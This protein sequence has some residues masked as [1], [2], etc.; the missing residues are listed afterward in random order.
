MHEEQGEAFLLHVTSGRY[1]GLN[2]SGVVVWNAL[3]DG[4]DPVQRLRDEWPSRPPDALENDA[5]VL[6]T[7]L[8]EAGLVQPR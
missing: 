5:N 4:A 8:L 1:F 7:A 2:H 3:R 6:V